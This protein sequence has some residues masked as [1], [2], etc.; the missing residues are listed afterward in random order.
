MSKG[1][2]VISIADGSQRG[3]LLGE[4]KKKLPMMTCNIWG[5]GA[6]FDVY[7]PTQAADPQPPPPFTK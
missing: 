1:N 3:R 6:R 4:V 2:G 5:G 7:P